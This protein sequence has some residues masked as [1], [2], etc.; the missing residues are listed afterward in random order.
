MLKLTIKG[1][2]DL[3]DFIE[4]EFCYYQIKRPDY[5]KKIIDVR[6]VFASHYNK[7]STNLDGMLTAM[8]MKFE[9]REHSGLDDTK[10]IARIFIQILKEGYKMDWTTN[11]MKH[12]ASRLLNLK[13]KGKWNQLR[14]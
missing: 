6:K 4:K 11:L 12:K 2:W 1:P 8:G 7:D 14:K 3:R 9:G 5:M 13:I 10:N